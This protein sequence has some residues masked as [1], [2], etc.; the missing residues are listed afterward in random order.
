MLIGPS[1][2][3]FRILREYPNSLQ[4]CAWREFLSRSDWASHYTAPE[5]FLEPF[6]SGK[7]P[8]AVL[9]GNGDK[10]VALLTGCHQGN[11]TFS[12]VP[13]RPQVCFD[14]ETDYSGAARALERGILTE[15]DSSELV[16]VIAWQPLDL[17]GFRVRALQGNVVLDLT[18]RPQA[19]FKQLHESLRRNIRYAMKH[20]VEVFEASSEEEIR[21]YYEVYSRW[22]HTPR[23][24]IIGAEV[25]FEVMRDAFRLRD[26]RRLFLARYQGKIIAGN[27]LR[28]LRGGLLEHSANSSLDEYARLKPNDLLIWK[29][30]EWGCAQGFARCSLGGAHPFL[31]RMGGCVMPVYRHRLDRSY[32]RWH[33]NQERLADMCRRFLHK[34][35]PFERQLRRLLGKS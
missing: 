23:K 9:V 26:S 30:V 3:N 17:Q 21:A 10:I 32:L 29:T 20:G 14:R 6:W 19:L 7:R 15:A 22:R 28:F 31:Q 34:V 2:F 13:G 4:E 16:T 1:V 35:P 8:F 18:K 24:T 5:Y 33:D 12:G 25:S 11:T 27:V